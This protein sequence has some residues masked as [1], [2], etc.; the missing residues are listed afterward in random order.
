MPAHAPAK[1]SKVPSLSLEQRI[2]RRGYERYVKRCNESG[3]DLDGWLHAEEEIL[4]ADWDARVDEA[5]EESF[6][7]SDAPA[8]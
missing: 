2:R 3:S 1:E 6:P 5:S 4:W 7:A 8:Y